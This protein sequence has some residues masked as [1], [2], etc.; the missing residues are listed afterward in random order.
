[1]TS[2]MCAFRQYS[3]RLHAAINDFDWEP[4]NQLLVRLRACRQNGNRVFLCGNGGSAANAVHM[5]NDFMYGAGQR[6]EGLKA[7][8]LTAN[9]AVITCI[10]NDVDYA[11]IFSYQLATQGE[12]GDILIALSGSGNSENII[13]TIQQAKNMD[14]QSFAILGYAGGRCKELTNVAIH[15]PID[16]MQISE[17]IQLIVA[18]MLIQQL[19]NNG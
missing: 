6:S 4:V 18:H 3:E 2:N 8:A 13:R 10:A 5:A 7:I 14:I 12:A 15:F 9:V 16:D 19:W 11:D 17:D 1:M